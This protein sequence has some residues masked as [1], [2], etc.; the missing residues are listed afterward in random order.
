M[1]LKE[2][3]KQNSNKYLEEMTA[4]RRHIHKNPELGLKEFETSKFIYNYLQDLG[5]EK[6]QKNI[7]KTGVTAFIEGNN[8]Q[9]TLGLRADMDAL[10][11]QEETDLSFTS[12]NKGIMHACGHDGHI[13]MAL[14]AG[15]IL[16]NYK[17]QLPVNI[18]LIFQPG[19]EMKYGA[20]YMVDDGVLQN[21]PVDAII[22]LHLWMDL[23]VGQ[24]G[25]KKGPVMAAM[26]KFDITIKGEKSHGAM[27]HKGVN[28]VTIGSRLALSLQSLIGEKIDPVEPAVLTIG[29]LEAGDTYNVLADKAE[30]KGT[31]RTIKKDSRQKIINQI[32][33]RAKN[34][35]RAYE[36]DV[37]VDIENLFP[38]TNNDGQIIDIIKNHDNDLQLKKIK[39]PSL[40]SE[41]F[42]FYLQEIPGA[43]FFIGCKNEQKGFSYPLHHSKFNFDEKA[44]LT[45]LKVL[46]YTA[47]S[48]PGNL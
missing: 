7:G 2:I 23:A 18:K 8:T 4:I 31:V 39:K 29:K 3:L 41:D 22:G 9:K 12:Q 45:G 42:S 32:K 11:I 44:L 43:M 46:I 47:H 5:L 36:A 37:E 21:P 14:V 17:E 10:P 35:A 34:I 19:E 48:F 25:L 20:K 26:N 6:V 1:K 24:V 16:N 15:K 40:G 28:A 13:A 27:P 30:L 33:K 38:I